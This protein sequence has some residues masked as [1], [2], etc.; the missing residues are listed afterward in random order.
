[1]SLQAC[2][3]LLPTESEANPVRQFGFINWACLEANRSSTDRAQRTFAYCKHA[4][5]SGKAR[6]LKGVSGLKRPRVREWRESER[7]RSAA[8]C[9]LPDRPGRVATR[10]SQIRSP[11]A[12]STAAAIAAGVVTHADRGSTHCLSLQS[13][14]VHVIGHQASSTQFRSLIRYGRMPQ[15]NIHAT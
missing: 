9:R 5:G 13:Y 7:H 14:T 15:C 10:C 11:A 8:L 6:L 4:R 3:E 2:Q 1:M 12:I